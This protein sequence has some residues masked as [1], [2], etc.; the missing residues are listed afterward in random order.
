MLIFSFS[1]II[2]DFWK[3]FAQRWKAFF[4]CLGSVAL[5]P[6]CAII[7]ENKPESLGITSSVLREYLAIRR[8]SKNIDPEEIVDGILL[9]KRAIHTINNGNLSLLSKSSYTKIVFYFDFKI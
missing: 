9:D 4:S 2:P 1:S 5:F 6:P 8:S 3:T 7:F